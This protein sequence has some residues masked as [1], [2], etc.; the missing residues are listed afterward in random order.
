[1]PSNYMLA[2]AIFLAVNLDL[3][4]CA[5]FSELFQFNWAPDH[6]ISEGDQTKLTLDNV[7]GNAKLYQLLC[8]SLVLVFFFLLWQVNVFS[9]VLIKCGQWF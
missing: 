3:A 2:I 7:S 1:M 4:M 6:I 5:N 8:L 9:F